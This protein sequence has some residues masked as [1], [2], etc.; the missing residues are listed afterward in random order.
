MK[1]FLSLLAIALFCAAPGIARSQ[2]PVRVV[3]LPFQIHTQEDL[4]YLAS[5]IPSALANQLQA[6]GAAIVAADPPPPGPPEQMTPD[7]FKKYGIAVGAD[8]VVWGSMTRIGSQFSLDVRMVEPFGDAEPYTAFEEGEKIETLPGMVKTLAGKVG[9]KIFKQVTITDIRIQG[10]KRIETDAID[11]VIKTA[12]GD[13]YS[14]KD[15]SADLKAVYAMG[16]FDD[17]RIESEDN[18]RGKSIVFKVK[19]KPTLRVIRFKGNRVF[20]DEKLM[21]NLSVSTGSILNAFKLET[22]V[23]RIET[24]YRDKNYHN[25]RVSYAIEP[26]EN[27]QA[28][29]TFTIEEGGKIW[30]RQIAFEGNAAYSDKD[31]KKLMKTAEKGL[32]SWITSSGD[33]NREDLDQDVDKIAAFYNNNGYIQIKVG[34]PQVEY[35]ADGI[36]VTMK[37]DE[38]PRFKVGRVDIAGDVILAKE[39]LLQQLNIS[40]QEYYSREIVRNDVLA[41]AD[42]Y[43]DQGYAYADI[44]PRIEQNEEKLEIHITYDIE[45]GSLV[46]FERIAIDGNTITRDKVIRRELGVYEQELYSG[47][48]LKKGVRNLQRLDFFDDIKVN[49]EK[50]S[51][52]DRMLLNI[53]VTEKPTGAFSFGGGYSNDE[54]LFGMASISQRNL[55]GRGQK[56]ELQAQVGGTTDKFTLS[57]VEPWFLDIPL[58]FGLDAYNWVTDYDEYDKDAL[59]GKVKLSYPV[60]D[61]TRAS[62]GYT[63]EVADIQNVTD[64]ASRSIKELEGNNTLSSILTGL[65]WD[66]RDK[67][68]NAT[69]GSVHS[70][71]L[72]YAGLGGDLTFTKYVAE[73]GWYIPLLWDVVGFVHGKAGY[74]EQNSG[75]I[76]PDYEKFYLGGINSMRGFEWQ[77]ISLKDEDGA[78][79]GGEKMVLFNVEILIPL[80]KKAGLMGVLFYDTGNVY[81]KDDDWD[82]GTLRESIGFGFRWYSPIGPIR[83]ENGYIIDPQPGED[84]N[85]RWEFS[86]G[87]QF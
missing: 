74:V 21:E 67:L 79:I 22:N 83:I 57:F 19:E 7:D 17:I 34:D 39:E 70:I 9:L 33:L 38:G 56:L 66:S 11:R 10:N 58:S 18:D 78:D 24:L 26:L 31:L 29:L 27:D 46:Y 4:S 76:L 5:E 44:S 12:P 62:F 6:E 13:V 30:I 32:F 51:A 84:T 40:K 35:R 60:F 50:G 42:L 61:N 14:A 15:L 49:T 73:T 20:D 45:K 53:N 25:V 54:N 68:F 72:E 86:M 37:I 77:G 81:S 1:R 71:S 52:D 41:L 85:G 55:F 36:Y 65:R 80:I 43:S 8:F 63:F 64:E 23:K 75:G 3:V 59:G 48:A 47:V 2:G 87:S 82:L 28:D 69:E 16:Y